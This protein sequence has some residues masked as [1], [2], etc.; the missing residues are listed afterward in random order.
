MKLKPH[1]RQLDIIDGRVLSQLHD[2]VASLDLND[3][4]TLTKEEAFY[5]ACHRYDAETQFFNAT[6]NFYSGVLPSPEL[7][8]KLQ[9]YFEYLKKF[10]PRHVIFR[11][12]VVRNVP[13]A[14]VH[15]HIDPRLYHR[16]SH[17]VHAVLQT[18]DQARHVYFDES[19]SAA[20]FHQ[21]E[22]GKL[23]DFDN[24]T[25]HGA[26]NLG[27]TSRIHIITDV[28]DKAY[29]S[30]YRK[31]FEANPNYIEPGTEDKYYGFLSSIH[32]L[33]GGNEGLRKL[34]AQ[35]VRA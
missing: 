5:D 24:I 22:V 33:Y 2:V 21:M 25:P 7:A 28:I 30:M 19:T 13:G 11:A 8:D 29:V 27:T 4:R 26:F 16:L 14:V 32:N 23:Y 31:V 18:N 9:P 35:T 34:Y 15:P 6:H 20:E 12:Q 10:F 3:P 1:I 17:R